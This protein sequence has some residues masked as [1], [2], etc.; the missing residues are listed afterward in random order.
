MTSPQS[1]S[2]I[3]HTGLPYLEMIGSLGKALDPKTYLEIGTDKGRSLAQMK[4][5]S[6]AI[7]PDFRISGNVMEGKPVCHL[8]QMSSDRFFR[9]FDLGAFLKPCV[10]MAFLDGMHRFEFLLR[11]FANTE[12]FCRRNSIILLHDCF[13]TTVEMTARVRGDLVAWT[14]DV[15]KMLPALAKHRPD[16]RMVYL[17]CPPTGL[18]AVTNL[19]PASE[20]IATSYWAI[21]DE[22]G[23]ADPANDLPKL[24]ETIEMTDSRTVLDDEKLTRTFW[25]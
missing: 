25:L 12:R 3:N 10:D 21:V 4:C 6:V 18:V 1:A 16:L 11:D 24:Y 17:D 2:L 8:F 7:D 15:W 20:V 22:F 19:S 5:A 23:D 14:G 9:E 13:P